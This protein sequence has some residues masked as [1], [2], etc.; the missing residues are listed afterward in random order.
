MADHVSFFRAR[1][2]PGKRQ[3]V[4]EQFEKWE[5]EQ[6]PKAA[7]FIRS[8]MVASNDDPDEIMGAVRFVVVRHQDGAHVALRLRLLLALPLV[9][10]LG[11]RLGL[12]RQRLDA[13]ERY[14][15]GHCVTS[16]S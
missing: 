10:L 6:K 4:L 5:R 9:H 15:I 8:I 1:A 16:S 3:A 11:D 14:V 12:A 13:K 7:G 2:L